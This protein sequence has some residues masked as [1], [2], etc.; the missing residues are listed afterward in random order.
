MLEWKT[1]NVWLSLLFSS[2]EGSIRAQYLSFILLYFLNVPEI[3]ALTQACLPVPSLGRISTPTLAW[4][5]SPSAKVAST[6]ECQPLVAVSSM[7]LRTSSWRRP[8]WVSWVSPLALGTRPSSFRYTSETTSTASWHAISSSSYVSSR[9]LRQKE[10]N[11]SENEGL[12]LTDLLHR[13][14]LVRLQ[15][16]HF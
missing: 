8:T 9:A 16:N 7:A 3:P 10:I 15:C 14:E 4:L 12:E 1:N 13:R 6:A 11:L 5:A 2:E